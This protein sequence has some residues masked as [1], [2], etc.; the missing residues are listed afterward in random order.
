[1]T[2]DRSLAVASDAPELRAPARV[3]PL[4]S[5]L[6][7]LCL[8]PGLCALLLRPPMPLDE[9]R[10]LGVAWEMWRHGDFLVPQLNG[11]PYSHKP[12]IL[13]WLVH[14]GWTVFGVHDW[15]PRLVPALSG[16]AAVAMTQRLARALQPRS[17]GTA[18]IAP[19]LLAGCLAWLVCTQMLLFDVL[20]TVWVLLGMWAL[21]NA[22]REDRPSAW[23]LIGLAIGGGLL[24]K[25]PV[26]FLQILV[27]GVLAPL[28]QPGLRARP[29]RWHGRLLAAAALGISVALTWAVP[30]AIRGGPDYAAAILWHQTADRMGDSFAHA[31]A[32]WFY[33]P[34]L[35]LLFLPWILTPSLWRQ[36]SIVPR[37]AALGFLL[38]WVI[39]VTVALSLV[40]G[41]QPHYILPV[42][43]AL[44]IISARCI[45]YRPQAASVPDRA[46][47]VGVP[48]LLALSG[49]VY[50]LWSA[51]AHGRGWLE[52]GIGW[53]LAALP[54]CLWVGRAD[55]LLVVA[56]RAAVTMAVVLVMLLA[57]FVHNP[58]FAGL[59]MRAPALMVRELQDSG[60]VVAA[61]DH[62]QDQFTY[63]GR[64]EKPIEVVP[65]HSLAEWAAAHPG[66]YAFAAKNP[67]PPGVAAT[68]MAEY[69]YRSDFLRIWRVPSDG[70]TAI[71]TR[72]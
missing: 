47:L 10:Y 20:L 3:F 71:P 8:L 69:P 57:G 51:A 19:W 5:A 21:W 23:L 63:L 14:A 67:L 11:V 24:T 54:A 64:L 13:F 6:A 65:T 29:W 60:A 46:A 34:V 27:P 55:A 15:W 2:R 1:V 18:Q 33:L 40:S 28:W 30:A 31:R 68:L 61:I 66:A 32:W 4:R 72:K 17:P 7:L 45:A 48:L 38:I 42:L 43:P 49:A 35:P 53:P 52:S 62:Y 58:A 36:W 44:A 16:L 56:R 50:L 59:D 12:P 22:A 70:A 26:V 37:D 25:G 39:S 41:K 9:L